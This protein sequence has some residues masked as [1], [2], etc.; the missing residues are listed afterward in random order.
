MVRIL[1]VTH[2]TSVDNERG[3]ASGHHDVPLSPLG[4]R[5]ARE[6]GA[7]Y[8]AERFDA[9]YVSDLQRALRTAALAFPGRGETITRDYRLREC[10]F[11]ALTQTASATIEATRSNYVETAYP[12]GESYRQVAARVAD[13][14]RDLIAANPDG[15]VLIVG[16]RATWFALEHLL[17]GVPLAKAVATPFAWQPGWWYT[18][19]A[20]A[21]QNLKRMN[22]A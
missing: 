7:R 9:I 3:L 20:R 22:R 2:S 6:L 1:Y 5:Q 12:G 18:I 17:R 21:E 14:L 11:G 15:R 8:A 13:F 10:D 16:H 19:D 4:E